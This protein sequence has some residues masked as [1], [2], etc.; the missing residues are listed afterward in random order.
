MDRGCAWR[1]RV[2]A[3]AVAGGVYGGSWNQ[4]V[5]GTGTLDGDLALA[6]Q[7]V[8]KKFCLGS[9]EPQ[10]GPAEALL[11]TLTLRAS[12]VAPATAAHGHK[13]GDTSLR[14]HSE[15]HTSAG[16]ARAQHL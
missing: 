1:R 16:G 12:H 11:S 13:A 7:E 9:C 6:G 5:V 2:S 4:A 10:C 14:T 3:L 15:T 8:G